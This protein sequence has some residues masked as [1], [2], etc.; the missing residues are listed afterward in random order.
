MR[1]AVRNLIRIVAAAL[2][3][4]G[5]LEFV[6][7]FTR[8]RTEQAEINL[9]HLALGAVLVIAGIVFFATSRKLAEKLTDDFEE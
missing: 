4:F 6:Y 2:V 1:R 9:W 5:A 7:E 8:Q 3:V